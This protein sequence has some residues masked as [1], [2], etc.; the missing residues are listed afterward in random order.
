MV[1]KHEAFDLERKKGRA[2][3]EY[4]HRRKMVVFWNPDDNQPYSKDSLGPIA[5]AIPLS[6]WKDMGKPDVVKI[7]VETAT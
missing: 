7:T 2:Y 6:L 3:Y 1:T 4:D 5:Y